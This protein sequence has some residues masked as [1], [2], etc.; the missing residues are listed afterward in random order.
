MIWIFPR[1]KVL[2]CFI[3]FLFCYMFFDTL[4]VIRHVPDKE[5]NLEKIIMQ[6]RFINRH[7]GVVTNH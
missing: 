6:L 2:F 4:I 5:V 3:F 7:I 1:G